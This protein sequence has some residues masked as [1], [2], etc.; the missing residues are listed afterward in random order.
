MTLLWQI[1]LA[2]EVALLVVFALVVAA[3]LLTKSHRGDA[4]VSMYPRRPL[5]RSRAR[6]RRAA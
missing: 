2:L 4:T 5:H 6:D 1:S 3:T